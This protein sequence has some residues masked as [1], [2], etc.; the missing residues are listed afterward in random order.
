VKESVHEGVET[1]KD[2]LDLPGTSEASVLMM[3]GC[4][5]VGLCLD[6]LTEPNE[7]RR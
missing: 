3:A 4:V 6:G 2:W 1:V 5:G 7:S